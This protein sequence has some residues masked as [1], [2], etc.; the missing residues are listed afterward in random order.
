[1]YVFAY[2]RQTLET[3]YEKILIIKYWYVAGCEKLR[4]CWLGPRFMS[5]NVIP[6][7]RVDGMEHKEANGMDCNLFI[8]AQYTRNP[9]K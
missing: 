9:W 2:M 5:Y 3:R 6:S 8:E 4:T 7:K 1:M